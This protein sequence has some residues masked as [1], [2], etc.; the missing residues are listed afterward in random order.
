ME[1]LYGLIFNLL[2][3]ALW[4]KPANC[5]SGPP[6]SRPAPTQV[7]EASPSIEIPGWVTR[8]PEDCFV[9]ISK[10]CPTIQEA[11]QLAI[12][13]AACEILQ[14]LGAE[15]R[16]THESVLSNQSDNQ[17]RRHLEE[18]LTYTAKW[19]IKSVQQNIRDS[20]IQQT[21][22]QHVCFV[23]IHFPASELEWLRRITIGPKVSARMVKKTGNRIFIQVTETNGVG[24]TL[25]DYQ[26]ETR[27][28]NQHAD[29][30]TM[31]AWKV[32][33]HTSDKV[34]GVV[35]EKCSV[36]GNSQRINIPCSNNRPKSLENVILGSEN[37]MSLSLS[38]HD[39]IGRHVT[40]P[41]Q[42]R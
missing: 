34:E 31:F 11:R 8:T 32:P 35:D 21:N 7:V 26:I 40:V 14:V 12:D 13:S 15:Y 16:L 9:G 17:I 33:K 29:I 18:R 3:K 41:V 38:G 5:H 42:I 37:Q 4:D 27:T 20:E 6:P 28:E 23:L 22:G 2:V 1:L 30:I 36:N 10:P 25:T 19:F 39:E 24:V